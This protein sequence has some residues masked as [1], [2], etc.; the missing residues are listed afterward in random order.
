M[1][2]QLAIFNQMRHKMTHNKGSC[3]L[4]EQICLI[5]VLLYHLKK[6]KMERFSNIN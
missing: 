3:S 5:Q 4:Q 1:I 6:Q 2:E